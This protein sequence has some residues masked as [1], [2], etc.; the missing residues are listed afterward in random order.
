[1]L[2]ALM[3]HPRWR[4]GRL[5]TGFIAEEYPNGFAPPVADGYGLGILAA[6]AASID[7]LKNTRRRHITDQVGGE[8][9]A[10]AKRRVVRID[11]RDL[12]REVTGGGEAPIKVAKVNGDGTLGAPIEVV[13]S[14]WPGQ[15]VWTGTVGGEQVSVQVRPVL[16]GVHLSYRGAAADIRVYTEAEANLVALMPEK[17]AAD[18]SKLLLCPMPG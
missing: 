6:V 8:P 15:P 7:H 4:E 18:T 5:S 3:Q 16:N 13:S 17:V 11:G 1:F 14:W 10:F 2:S 9:F 12:H